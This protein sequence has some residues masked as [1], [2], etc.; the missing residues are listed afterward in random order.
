MNNS[1]KTGENQEWIEEE[2]CMLPEI[3]CATELETKSNIQE[4]NT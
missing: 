3:G 1:R 4:E 2:L